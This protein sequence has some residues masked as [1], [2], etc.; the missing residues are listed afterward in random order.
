MP[1]S[2]FKI[3]SYYASINVP[4]WRNYA[5]MIAVTD[6]QNGVVYFWFAQP[7]RPSGTTNLS[8]GGGEVV[9][10]LSVFDGMIDLL[11]NEGPMYCRYSWGGSDDYAGIATSAEPPGEGE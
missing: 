10:E 3:E 11:R 6:G 7:G 5:A 2:S 9:A 4:A 8:A 1:A